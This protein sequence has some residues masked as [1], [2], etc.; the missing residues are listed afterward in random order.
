MYGISY[1]KTIGSYQLDPL[2]VLK[3]ENIYYDVR[4]KNK[5]GTEDYLVVLKVHEH[6]IDVYVSREQ[7]NSLYKN[8]IV[9][10]Q[11]SILN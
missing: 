2:R 7:M 6:L 3:M 8:M 11:K 5:S 1:C 4:V 10:K 9:Y